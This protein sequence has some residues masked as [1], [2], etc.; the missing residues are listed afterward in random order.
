[1][2]K[3]KVVV[4]KSTTGEH[5]RRESEEWDSSEDSLFNELFHSVYDAALIT[6]MDGDIVDVNVRAV[7]KL[8]C[9]RDGLVFPVDDGIPMLNVHDARRL[10]AVK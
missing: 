6:N 3:K 9:E 5:S 10:D 2:G 7:E 8:V 1:M 4:A